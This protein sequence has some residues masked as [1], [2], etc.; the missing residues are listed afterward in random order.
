MSVSMVRTDCDADVPMELPTCQ[1]CI[2]TLSDPY[3]LQCGHQFCRNCIIQYSELKILEGNCD[4][5][6]PHVVDAVSTNAKHAYRLCDTK[7]E[8]CKVLELLGSNQEI[9]KKYERFKYFHENPDGRECPQCNHRQIGSKSKP[10]M[11]CS[12]CHCAYCFVHGGAHASLTCAE[13][14]KSV[15]KETAA[16]NSLLSLSSKPCPGCGIFV[17]KSG[18]CNHMKVSV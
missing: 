5:L 15:S 14:E 11:I 12:K 3:E 18:G 8:E 17:S 16:T 1:I 6:C 13:Y 7:I 4:I 9:C 10:E 2:D